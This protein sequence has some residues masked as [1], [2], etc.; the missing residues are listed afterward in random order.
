[1]PRDGDI[2]H[3]ILPTAATMVGVCITVV[4]IVSLIEVQAAMVTIID[5]MAAVGALTFLIS[6]LLSYMSLRSPRVSSRL[7]RFA[8]LVFLLG[9]L[10]LV[11]SGFMI[12]WEIGQGPPAP[13]TAASETP[14]RWQLDEEHVRGLPG[15][16]LSA[17]WLPS[18]LDSGID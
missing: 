4:G 7:E 12:A 15:E 13:A 6:T 16:N 3:H 1:M 14:R 11:I 18:L 17:A 9:L 5:E 10:I 8:D 2:S